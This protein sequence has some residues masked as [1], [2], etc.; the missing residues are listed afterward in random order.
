MIAC[1]TLA[2][3]TAEDEKSTTQAAESPGVDMS[4]KTAYG[5]V[6]EVSA[7]LETINAP[8]VKIGALQQQYE[9]ALASAKQ[10]A[11]DRRGTGHNLATKA[12]EVRPGLQAVLR[13]LDAIE[14]PVLLMPFY[15]DTRKMLATRIEA[16]AKTIK[17][18]DVEQADGD[19]EAVYREAEKDYESAN[20]LILQLNTEM[21]RINSS[22]QEAVRSP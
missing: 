8:I 11:A 1:L 2:C 21:N 5:T 14:P 12:T 7:Y 16:L 20:Q 10:G 3:G 6:A 19:F 15:R 18:W 17:G 22:V 9:E 4:K 13:E